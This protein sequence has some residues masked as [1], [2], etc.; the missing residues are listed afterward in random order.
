MA[1]PSFRETL[2]SLG[3]SPEEIEDSTAMARRF[4]AYLHEPG[5][6]RSAESVLSF[7]AL[8]MEEGNNTRPN[9]LALVRYCRFLNDKEMTVA[10]LELVDGGEVAENLYRMVG[11]RF[12]P[13][14]R[15]E[16]FSGI[17]VP[18]YGTPSTRKP[19]Y[20]QPVIERLERR[21]GTE[22]CSD[23]LS[24]CLRDLPE[25][26]FIQEREMLRRAG[27]MDAFLRQRQA[28]FLSEL[29]ACHLEGRLFFAQEITPEVL[30]FVRADP[31]MGG[32]RREGAVIYETKIP[33]MTA[34]YLAETDPTLKRYYACHCPWA[35]EAIRQGDVR[36]A[37]TFCQ[38]SGGFHKK[39]LEVAL[40]RPLKVRV[41]ESVL[42]GDMRCRFAIYLDDAAQSAAD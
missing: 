36:P 33:Y 42:R 38:C 34:K 20:V 32:G 7:A 30:D 17:G 25:E 27:N 37:E 6:D 15:D 40:G 11:E 2:E 3:L 28:A 39:P 41:L 4:V 24:A 9:Y 1:E 14:I 23:F 35:R 22:S 10:F 18:P 5:R 12:G 29:E 13:A 19:G 16:I 21:I 31:E 8:L 26:D